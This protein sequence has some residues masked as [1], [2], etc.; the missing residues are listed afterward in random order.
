MSE[1][2]TPP[3]PSASTQKAATNPPSPLD[4]R[5]IPEKWCAAWSQDDFESWI[6]LYAP[7]A[8]Y[9]DHA[10]RLIR[11]TPS[12]LKQHFTVWRNAQPDFIM[13]LYSD[14]PVYWSDSIVEDTTRAVFRTT[15]EGTSLRDTPMNVASGKRFRFDAVVEVVIGKGDGLVRSVQE[16]YSRDFN[17]FD[18]DSGYIVSK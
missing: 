15:N 11:T 9:T 6:S 17:R 3:P 5:S 18:V 14:S 4:L 8:I 10:F 12:S 7:N 16:W 2:Q 13:T 1:Q